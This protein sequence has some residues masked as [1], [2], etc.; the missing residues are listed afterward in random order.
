MSY[1]TLKLLHLLGVILFLG[2]IVV[3]A[4]WKVTADRTGNPAVIAHGQRQVI[5]TDV[6][7]TSLG[8]VLIAGSGAAMIAAA[9]WDVMEARWLQWGIGL[10]ALSGGIWLIVLIPTQ[11]QQMRLARTFKDGGDVP[12]RYRQLA[13]RWNLFGGLATVLPFLNLYWMVFKG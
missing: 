7:F 6:I 1:E 5:L 11:V 3:T 4:W 8:V 12:E 13:A 10:F 2:N 9:G